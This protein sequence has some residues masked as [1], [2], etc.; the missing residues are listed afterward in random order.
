MYPI[1]K[2]HAGVLKLTLKL[3]KTQPIYILVQQKIRLENSGYH[4]RQMGDKLM[5][6]IQPLTK[7][8]KR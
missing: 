8:E 6:L 3:N 1:T 2:E 5:L 4:Q 7:Q